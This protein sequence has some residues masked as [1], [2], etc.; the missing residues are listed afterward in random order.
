[1]MP[2]KSKIRDHAMA[3]VKVVLLSG[4]LLTGLWLLQMVA[5]K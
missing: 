4:G 1:M 5:Q 3:T 2:S